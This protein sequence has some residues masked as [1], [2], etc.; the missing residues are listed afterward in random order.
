MPSV[1]IDRGAIKFMLKGADIM[2][3]G[4]TSPGIYYLLNITGG[5]LPE[6]NLPV[7]TVVI[8]NA[9]G[10]ETALAIGKLTKSVDNMYFILYNLRKSSNQGIGI[11][12][13]HFL[14]DGLW[15]SLKTKL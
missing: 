6:T 1:Q 12:L 3:P 10:K 11:Q 7:G 9:E 5:R 13:I 8:I 15:K 4:L 14:G 2:C